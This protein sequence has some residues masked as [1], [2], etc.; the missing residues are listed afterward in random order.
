MYNPQLV[1]YEEDQQRIAE[2]CH[3][4]VRDANARAVFLVDKDGQLI[5]TAGDH[6]GLDTASVASLTAGTFAATAGLARLLGER[7]FPQL[8]HEGERESIQLSLVGKRWILVVIFDDRTTPGLV[9]L[10]VRKIGEELA[11]VAEVMQQRAPLEG[12]SIFS[13]ITDQDIDNLF[14]DL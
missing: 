12:V 1:L 14:G 9:R 6:H 7:E 8:F 13:N 5:L 10:R 2:A 4:L 3:R 11:R